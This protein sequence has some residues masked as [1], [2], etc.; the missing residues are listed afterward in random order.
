[1]KKLPLVMVAISTLWAQETTPSL[2]D[3]SKVKGIISLW[4]END[5][6]AFKNKDRYYT[7]GLRISYQEDAHTFWSLTQEINTPSDTSNPNPPATD[8]PY[9][10]A[11]YLTYGYG[12]ILDRGGKKDCLFIIEGDLG[13]IGPSALGETIQNRFH[14]LIGTPETAGWGTQVPDEMV[15]NV[16]IEFRRRFLF[17]QSS[18]GL[19]DLITRGALQLGTMRTEAIFGAQLRWGVGFEQNWGQTFIRQGSAYNP[20][21][22]DAGSGKFSSWLFADAQVEVVMRNYA[23]DGTNFR[24]SRSVTRNPVVGQLA[25]GATMCVHSV[26]LSYYLAMRSKEFETQ[27]DPHY[28]GGFRGEVK[29]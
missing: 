24:E 19:R 11:L 28:F 29:F 25:I 7:Q 17:D 3:V 10:A 5:K 18:L 13:V 22:S 26:V 27:L 12:K 20:Q 8:L 9:S 16:D 2:P 6:F 15:L 23:T 4:E 21:F 1:M 14:D